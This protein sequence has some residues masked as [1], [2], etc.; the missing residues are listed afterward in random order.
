[1]SKEQ[2]RVGEYKYFRNSS[3]S[4]ETVYEARKRIEAKRALRG[5]SLFRT[6]P[7]KKKHE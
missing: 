6:G 1:M 5:S 7:K 2:E 3:Y 4:G